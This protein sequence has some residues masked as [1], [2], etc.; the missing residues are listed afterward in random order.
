MSDEEKA[1]LVAVY[2]EARRQRFDAEI[3]YQLNAK[4]EPESTLTYRTQG[5]YATSLAASMQ[6][7]QEAVTGTVLSGFAATSIGAVNLAGATNGS[8]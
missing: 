5:R 3:I 1:A 7:T 4:P 6:A 2:T 8:R